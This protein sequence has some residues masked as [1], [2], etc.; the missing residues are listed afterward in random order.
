MLSVMCA[1]AGTALPDV[2]R[3]QTPDGS[4]SALGVMMMPTA[5]HGFLFFAAAAAA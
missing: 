2:C 3:E 1:S 5:M 4:V